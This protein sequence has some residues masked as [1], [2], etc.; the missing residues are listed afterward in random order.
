MK[1]K[2]IRHNYSF[3]VWFAMLGGLQATITAYF[4][5]VSKAVSRQVFMNSVLQ[6]I[7]YIKHRSAVDK[8]VEESDA[9][10]N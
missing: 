8:E 9:G 3:L 2:I 7:F 4:L 5:R 1:V 6:D 10:S